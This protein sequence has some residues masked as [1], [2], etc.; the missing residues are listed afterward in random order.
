ML[1]NQFETLLSD[2]YYCLGINR[3]ESKHVLERFCINETIRLD[4]AAKYSIMSYELIS[5]HVRDMLFCIS[6]LASLYS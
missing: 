4:F 6:R 2:S 5:S 3:G 1:P